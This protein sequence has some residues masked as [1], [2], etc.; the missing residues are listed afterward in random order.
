[1]ANR[2]LSGQNRVLGSDIVAAM[3]LDETNDV[4]FKGLAVD[5]G[6]FLYFDMSQKL[7]INLRISNSYFAMLILPPSAPPGTQINNCIAERVFGAASASGL[8]AWIKNLDAEV[9]DSFENVARIRKM[10]LSPPHQV[11]VTIVKK[12]FFQKGAGRKEEAL[13]RGLGQI[14]APRVLQR[15]LAI[16]V[17]EGC[18]EKFRGNDGDVYAPT[19]NQAGRMR[20]MLYDL[21]S[22]EDRIW[23][24]VGDL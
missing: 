9:Y 22:S 18:L 8:P 12:T 7:A 4:D 13:L 11:L 17:R 10:A 20:Q 5:Q 24:E 23:S 16:L 3:V 14:V 2:S 1:M 6:K 15:V 21:R 19:R